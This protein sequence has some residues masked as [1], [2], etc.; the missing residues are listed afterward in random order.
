MMVVGCEITVRDHIQPLKLCGVDNTG[1]MYWQ[2]EGNSE[3]AG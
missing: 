1:K 3:G 2:I